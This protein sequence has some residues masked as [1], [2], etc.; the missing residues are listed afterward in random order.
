QADH[1]LSRIQDHK[2]THLCGAPIV[3]NMLLNDFHKNGHTLVEPVQFA[4]GGA[5]PPSP[6][7]RRAQEIG[8]DITH[9][10]GLTESYGPS[11]L[12]VWQNDWAGLETDALAQKMARQGVG[13]LAIDEL[14]VAN[15]DDGGFVPAD[16]QTLGELLMRGNTLMKGYLKNEAATDEAFRNGW[17][18]TGDLAV[19][20]PDGY[21]EVKD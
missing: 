15:P 18:H 21:V 20:H 14:A 8:F 2:V 11:A 3:L 13:T 16:G 7:I 10:Y 19:M 1:V 17:F 9:L 12:C 5:A 6:V 4:T